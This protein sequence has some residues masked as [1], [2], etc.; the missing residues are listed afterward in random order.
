[1][2]R[3]NKITAAILNFGRKQELSLTA[4]DPAQVIPGVICLVE[5]TV[6]MNGISLSVDIAEGLPGFTGDASR[7]QQV[8]LNLIN[9]A[10][11]AVTQ[12]HGNR[13]GKIE[14]RAAAKGE[15]ELASAQVEIRVTDNGCGIR[16]DH[17]DRIF[18]P[19]F[20]TK[21]VGRGTGLGLSVCY[22]IIESFGGTMAVENRPDEGTVFSL[23]LPVRQK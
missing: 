21:A 11:D 17:M 15:K 22:G 19:F 8:M 4:L 14:V 10:V 5:N 18:S 3:C 2:S 12:R 23:C 1:M 20:T 6:K 16:P 7:F 9:N 13:G